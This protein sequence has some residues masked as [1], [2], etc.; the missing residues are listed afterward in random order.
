MSPQLFKAQKG[1]TR[2]RVRW[3]GVEETMG[4]TLSQSW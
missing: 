2:E 1:L 3:E 4:M